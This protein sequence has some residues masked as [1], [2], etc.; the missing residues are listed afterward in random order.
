MNIIIA[1]CGKVG[2]GLALRLA[3]QGHAITVVDRHE[4]ARE[5][6]GANFRGRFIVGVE[7]DREILILAGIETADGLAATSPDDETNIVVA[8]V[9]RRFFHVPNVVARIANPAQADV[10]SRLGL[11]TVAPTHWTI[12]HTADILTHATL[13]SVLTLG[14]GE[15]VVMCVDIPPALVGHGVRELNIVNE[16][17]VIAVVRHGCALFP[18]S[19]LTLEAGDCAYVAAMASG[20]ERLNRLLAA[21]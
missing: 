5:R 13:Q 16:T 15:M 18:T 7:F 8:N 3:E 4:A 17:Q 19:G 12:Q 21:G 14:G 9:A 11:Q 1:G 2:S 6:L 10:F 20:S